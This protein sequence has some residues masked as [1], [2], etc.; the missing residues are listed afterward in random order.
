MEHGD[1]GTLNQV[2][3]RTCLE[4]KVVLM[5]RTFHSI[6]LTRNIIVAFP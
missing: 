1:L 5:S 2:S 4:I 6:G 3:Y